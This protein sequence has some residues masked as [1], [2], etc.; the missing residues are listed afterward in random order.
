MSAT[1]CYRIEAPRREWDRLLGE[2]H[3]L[4]TLGVIECDPD[5]PRPYLLAYFDAGSPSSRR[6]LEL[7]NAARGIRV[8]QPEPVPDTDWEARWR[9]GLAPR[10]VGA[11]W[12]RPSWC[13]SAGLPELVIDPER[14]F[15]S[16]EHATTRLA[17]R[18]LTDALVPGDSVLDLGTG[19]GVLGLG[20]LRCG[21][22]RALGVDIDP[23]AVRCARGNAARNRLPLALVAG[24]LD[25]LDPDARFGVVVANMLWSRLEA[26]IPRLVRH[27]GRVLVISGFLAAEHERVART[28]AEAGVVPGP[29]AWEEQSGDTW[30]VV[31]CEPTAVAEDHVRD[32]QSSSRSLKVSSKG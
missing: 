11:L 29:P 5:V 7:R 17:L 3:E 21:A 22:A 2:L 16:G 24:T 27:T 19:S 15:G 1:L 26:Q 13:D 10:R 23:V 20:A 18:L 4:G 9:E 32:R 12:I 8:A 6:A 31:L 25:A 30:G 14:A 28:L